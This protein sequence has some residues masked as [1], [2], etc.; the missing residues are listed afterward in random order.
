MSNGSFGDIYDKFHLLSGCSRATSYA[1]KE[2][3]LSL[4]REH[5]YLIQQVYDRVQDGDILVSDMYLS[6]QDIWQLLRSAGFNKSVNIHVSYGGK[7]SGWMWDRLLHVYDI[8]LHVGDNPVSDVRQASLFSVAAE[9]TTIHA[10]IPSETAFRQLGPTG[11]RLALLLRRMRHRNPYPPGTHQAQLFEEQVAVNLPVL[12]VAAQSLSEIMER[13]G[14]SRL[15]LTTRD[16]CL[17]AKVLEAFYPEIHV[18]TLQNSRRMYLNP[19]KEYIAYLNETYVWGKSLIFDINAS[20]RA[21]RAV[22]LKHFNAY[23]RVHLLR[24]HDQN[25]EGYVGLTKSSLPYSL[26]HRLMSIN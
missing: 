20:F 11:E 25:T 24:F 5:V 4:E 19:T 23:P 22:F 16:C 10:P 26:N 13:E 9:L 1:L 21:G 12:L 6:T 3:E 15:L 8:Q 2:L 17:L 18:I 7:H 14:L